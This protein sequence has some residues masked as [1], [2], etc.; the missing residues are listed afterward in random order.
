MATVTAGIFSFRK[1]RESEFSKSSN[2][3]R[4]R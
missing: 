3:D 2:L 4:F 1:I